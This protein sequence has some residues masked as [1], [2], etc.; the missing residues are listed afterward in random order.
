LTRSNRSVC[1][2]ILRRRRHCRTARD[3]SSRA[4]PHED[5]TGENRVR[6]RDEDD[7]GSSDAATV[8]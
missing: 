4:R 2:A 6:A 7:R 3:G 5:V 8:G 1:V